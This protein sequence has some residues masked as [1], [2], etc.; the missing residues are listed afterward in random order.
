MSDKKDR[1]GYN[2]RQH[3]ARDKRHET[4]R[5]RLCRIDH[6]RN[7]NAHRGIDHVH[8]VH[9]RNRLTS[10]SRLKTALASKSKSTMAI[11]VSLL[12]SFVKGRLN[13]DVCVAVGVVVAVTVPVGVGLDVGVGV[14]LGLPVTKW[15]GYGYS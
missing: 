14:G 7:I 6:F 9:H 5:F 8:F 1:S 13:V 11:P 10:I 15:C 3:Q 4:K 2:A 12:C